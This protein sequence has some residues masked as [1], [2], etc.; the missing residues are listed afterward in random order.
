MKFIGGRLR[1]SPPL[2][3]NS[4]ANPDPKFFKF[5]LIRDDDHRQREDRPSIVKANQLGKKVARC[6]KSDIAMPTITTPVVEEQ[7]RRQQHYSQQRQ[8]QVH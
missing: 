3:V 6:Y 2:V 4:S 5:F 1:K 8:G 7:H